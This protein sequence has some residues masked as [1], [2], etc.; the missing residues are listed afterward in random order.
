MQAETLIVE[1]KAGVAKIVLNRPEQ[2]HSI[3]LQMA[4]ELHRAALFCEESESVRAV[5]LTSTGKMFCAGGDLASFAKADNASQALKEITFYLHAA[6]SRF[7]RMDAPLVVAVNGMAAGAGFSLALLGDLTLAAESARFTMAY[8]AVALS[9]DAGSTF[10]LPR[11]IGEKRAKELML[12]NRRLSAQEALDWGLVNQVIPDAEL[13][14]QA[15]TLAS[16][17]AQG[18]TRAF[19]AV[20]SLLLTQESLEAQ[21][22]KEARSIA[23]RGQGEDG[24]EGIRAFLEKRS[25]KYF[26]KN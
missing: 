6:I 13:L 9:P 2:A 5:L 18:P 10:N 20:K 23:A 12:T 26:G 19:G 1:E 24:A 22:D 8:T 21:L 11:L 25:P 15:E 14:E 7:A 4:E 16:T 17:L 3:N